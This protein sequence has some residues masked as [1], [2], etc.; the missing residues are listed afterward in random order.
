[1]VKEGCP[2]ASLLFRF[3]VVRGAVFSARAALQC[4]VLF[5]EAS[6]TT[7]N[8]MAE[9]HRPKQNGLPATGDN[10]AASPKQSD[11]DPP[12]LP[13]TAS[14]SYM[15]HSH[16]SPSGS[17]LAGSR[18]TDGPPPA[19]NK[20]CS[21]S[22]RHSQGRLLSAQQQIEQGQPSPQTSVSSDEVPSS[23]G[24]N[25]RRCS[26]PDAYP[27]R[28]DP[29]PQPANPAAAAGAVPSPSTNGT[30]ATRL[31]HGS[32]FQKEWTPPPQD[33]SNYYNGSS[34]KEQIQSGQDLQSCNPFSTAFS[35]TVFP[36]PSPA[37]TLC[38]A[39]DASAP[40]TA[41]DMISISQVR[42]L[43]KRDKY[44]TLYSLI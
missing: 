33:N 10:Y 3:S 40:G 13:A 8:S 37:S 19:R 30:Q 26:A 34:R 44:R 4:E 23:A 27:L 39:A 16:G 1:M 11:V 32:F 43:R 9:N 21:A 14:S 24:S 6:P 36:Y 22:S 18:V 28:H 17:S 20:S 5:S 38:Q 35:S 15:Y 41:N 12:S 7:E 2:S 29:E 42:P 25:G 31:S